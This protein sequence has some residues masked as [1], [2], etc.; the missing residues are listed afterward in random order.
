MPVNLNKPGQVTS[1]VFAGMRQSRRLAAL[2]EAQPPSAWEDQKPAEELK[3]ASEAASEQ[4]GIS[5]PPGPPC[6]TQ[7]SSL[8]QASTLEASAHVLKGLVSGIYIY[9]YIYIY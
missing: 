7:H 5:H 1:C 6:Q 4:P 3:A 2:A 9:I 8:L